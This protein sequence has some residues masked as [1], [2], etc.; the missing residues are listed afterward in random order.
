M[1]RDQ[2]GATKAVQAERA[3][4]GRGREG[5]IDSRQIQKAEKA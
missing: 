4:V 3:A 2:P 1:H 5:R